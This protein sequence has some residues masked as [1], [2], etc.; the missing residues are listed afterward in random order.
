MGEN[1]MRRRI[2]VQ[3]HAEWVSLTENSSLIP[4]M[5]AYNFILTPNPEYETMHCTYRLVQ[6]EP[7]SF[8]QRPNFKSFVVDQACPHAL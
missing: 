7:S 8:F 5:L 1:R 2:V 3:H 6:A 4:A